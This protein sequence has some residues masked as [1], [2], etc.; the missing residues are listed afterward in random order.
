[1]E[2]TVIYGSDDDWGCFLNDRVREGDTMRRFR[3][4]GYLL[5]ATFVI[6]TFPRHTSAWHD[7]T[8]LAIAKAS[9][10]H[11]WFN[12]TGADMAKL[13]AGEIESH[14]HYVNNPKDTVVTPEMVLAQAAKYNQIDEKGH[15]YG[16]IIGSLRDYIR[17]KQ[18]GKYGEYHLGFCAH[19]V[20]DLSQPL[21]NTVYNAFN[22]KYHQTIDGI[23]NDEVLDNPHRIKLYPIT[24]TLEEALA[25]QVARIANLSMKLGYEIEAEDRLLTKEEAYTQISHSVSLFKAIL[26]FV[27]KELMTD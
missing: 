17:D 26:E 22:R 1:L 23:I 9:G 12:A 10:Y 24:I 7:E 25:R 15:L 8:H 3:F 4:S 6:V 14:N 27:E 18:K 16:A 5:L 13:K 21:H 2:K 19:Y 20:G 11:K